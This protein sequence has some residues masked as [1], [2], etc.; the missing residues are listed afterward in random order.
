L[1]EKIQLLNDE[2]KTKIFI[3]NFF[4]LNF[5]F[6]LNLYFSFCLTSALIVENSNNKPQYS[7][8]LSDSL[9]EENV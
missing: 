8:L 6:D 2:T 3:L 5:I 9:S 4:T 1:S 7:F